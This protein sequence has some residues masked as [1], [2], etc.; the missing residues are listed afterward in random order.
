MHIH[1]L[2]NENA[3]T[4]FFMIRGLLADVTPDTIGIL[5]FPERSYIDMVEE[6]ATWSSP[7]VE[8]KHCTIG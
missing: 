8:E 7:P 5:R 6:Q 4:K 1:S 2:R 3:E